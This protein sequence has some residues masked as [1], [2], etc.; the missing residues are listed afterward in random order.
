MI[1]YVSV[2][3]NDS[4]LGTK[5]APF[6]TINHAAQIAVAGDTVRVFGGTYRES[7][8]PCNK[9][10]EN[11][12]ITYEAVEGETPVIKGSEIVTDWEHIEGTVWKKVIPNSLFG[13]FNP[14]ATAIF[15][16]WCTKPADKTIHLGDVYINGVSM[17]EAFS[18]DELKIAEKREEGPSFTSPIFTTN[19][20]ILKPENTVYQ[21]Y[22]EVYDNETAI[23]CN[24]GKYDPNAELI[25]IN[26]RPTCFF[27]KQTGIN[28]ITVRGFEIAQGATQWSPPTAEQIGLIGP[29]WAKGWIIEN[30]CVHDSKC[31]GICI[32]KEISTG[33]N[34]HSLFAR[35]SGYQNQMEC[36]FNALR[37]GWSKENIGSHIVR[38]N[39]I[40]D[41]GQTGI[42]GHLGCI[43]SRIEHNHI[44][45]IA[46]KYEF[47]GH[48]IAG[49]KLHAPIDVVIENNNFHECSLGIWLDWQVQGT[50]ITKNLFYNN[51][52]DIMIEVT[53]GPCLVDNNIFLSR[54]SIQNAA[55]GT[56]FVHNIVCGVSYKYQIIDRAT[57]YHYPHTTAMAG[58]A[59]VYGGDDR[60]YNNIMVGR[61]ELTHEKLG[62]FGSYMDEYTDSME[63]YMANIK[64]MRG[65]HVKYH[66]MPQVVWFDGNA[67][68]GLAKPFRAE[69]NFVDANGFDASIE[70][71]DGEWIL[72]VILPQSVASTAVSPVT[73]ERLGTPRITEEPYENPDGTP[74]DFT[75][76]YFGNTRDTVIAGPFAKLCAGENRFVV[77]KK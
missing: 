33:H 28:Y 35:K 36:V 65:D 10:E 15:G 40:Y 39:V 18:L 56:A 4:A 54:Y 63:E 43:F 75:K 69:K 76:D 77:W 53:H 24:F 68:A 51:D 30:N 62:Y 26:V 38:N 23:W 70:E 20:K 32:G 66:K 44:F 19:E 25:E 9:G 41:C 42:V 59:F 60:F 64:V 34:L 22:A 49:I 27:P 21:W 46:K 6:R 3:G 13:D 58:Y 11:A 47:W 1:Y 48:E 2:N 5:E 45:R 14:F 17:Y 16:D 73:T 31:S 55:Q 29:H 74:I 67:Y 7:V 50:R 12:R 57:P 61:E 8:D 52:R 71:K 72:T 37:I